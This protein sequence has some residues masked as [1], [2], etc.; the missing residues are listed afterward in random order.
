[1]VNAAAAAVFCTSMACMVG[2]GGAPHALM[3]IAMTTTVRMEKR[4]IVFEYLLMNLAIG[5]TAAKRGDAVIFDNNFPIAFRDV[6]TTEC[7]EILFAGDKCS[8]TIL[9]NR[10]RKAITSDDQI[11]TLTHGR[12]HIHGQNNG[13][14]WFGLVGNGEIRGGSLPGSERLITNILIIVCVCRSIR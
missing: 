12:H 1:M 11:S 7:F 9:S 4:F 13:P 5:I 14:F 3:S 2:A 8:C 10:A 6:E